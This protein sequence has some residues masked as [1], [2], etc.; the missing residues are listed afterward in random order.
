MHQGDKDVQLNIHCCWIFEL[1][2]LESITGRKDASTLKNLI[3]TRSDLF[4]KPYGRQPN[5][6]QDQAFLRARLITI[7]YCGMKPGAAAI[8]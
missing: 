5:R 3:T 1:A 6:I 8:W 4:S 7:P 2:E